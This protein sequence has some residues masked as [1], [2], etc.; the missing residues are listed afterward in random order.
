MGPV[1]LFALGAAVL[2]VAGAIKGMV[3]IGLPAASISLLTL[4]VEPRVAIALVLLPMVVS[5]GWQ[6]WQMGGIGL[7]LRRYWL[8]AAVLA[9]VILLT[10]ALSA[11]V[12][13][14]VIFLATGL[15]I[16][17]FSAVNLRF[18]VPEL[19]LR[20]DRLAQGVFGAVAGVLGGL[21][22][23][24]GA[25]MVIYLTARRVPKDEFVRATGLLIFLGSVPL[26]LGYLRQGLLTAE[27]AAVSALLVVP[28]LIGFTIGAHVR[29]R[30]SNDGFRR[31]LLYVFLFLGLN[32]VRKGVW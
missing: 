11:T 8:F 5:N 30:L 19:G 28:T 24:W 6:V 13:D 20:F 12:P 29:G 27:L 21:S 3:G 10:V 7:A 14:R 16:V 25:P 4:A 1:E 31:L 32:L 17:L 15:S 26:T 23:I 9:G 18:E 2:L 22:G